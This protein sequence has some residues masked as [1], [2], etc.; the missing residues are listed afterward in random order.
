MEKKVVMSKKDYLR[1]VPFRSWILTGVSLLSLIFTVIFQ[2]IV[3]LAPAN[4][5]RESLFVYQILSSTL[6]WV[7]VITASGA[8]FTLLAHIQAKE[9][10]MR[11]TIA[12]HTSTK[13]VEQ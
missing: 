12:R 11:F 8:L 3:F 1:V 10:V 7:F 13:K 6:S 2:R 4:P 5:D 9:T